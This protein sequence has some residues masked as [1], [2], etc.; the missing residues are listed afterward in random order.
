MHYVICDIETTGGSPKNSKIT[1]I[2]I[3]KHD[4]TKIIDTFETLIN[5]EISIPPFIVNLTGIND[6]MVVNSPK[7]YEV[8]KE[9]LEFTKGCVFVAHNVAFDYGVLRAEFCSLGYDFRRPH[10]CTVRASRYVI[11]GYDS[12]SLGKLTKTLGIELVGRHRAGGDALATAYL[13][14]LIY[15]KDPNHLEN[16]IQKELDPKS[17]HPQLNVHEIDNIPNKTGV[18]LFYDE[19]NRL[20]YIGK[21]IHL[22]KRIEQHLR[23]TKSNKAIQMQQE[24]A[25]VEYELTGSELIALLKESELIKQYSPKYNRALQKKRTPYGLFNYIDGKGYNRFYIGA[26]KQVNESP[27]V[28]FSTQKEGINFLKKLVEKNRLCQKLCDLYK[29]K[30]ACFHYE[31][32]LCDGACIQE[33]SVTSYNKKCNAVIDGLMFNHSSFYIVEKGRDKSEKSLV[34]IKNGS[35][36][37]YGFAPFHFNRLKAKDWEEFITFSKENKDT[38][39]IV[40]SYLRKKKELNLVYV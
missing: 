4:G 2:A 10:L 17:L 6:Q 34:Y 12:Y 22:K 40:S 30:G 15:Q 21:S 36:E 1:E 39:T 19:E 35:V 38:R 26:T 33:E 28:S 18:Y 29:T 24:I 23:N 32:K 37:G 14:E 25:R 8:A 13:F 20:I 7:F 31:V 9:I 11:P 5:P 16:F 27:I 3:F